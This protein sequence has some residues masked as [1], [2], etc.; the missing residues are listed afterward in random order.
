VLEPALFL[1]TAALCLLSGTRT[2]H[3]ALAPELVD[4]AAITVWA[5]AVVALLV[6]LQVE[7]SRLPVDD[8][9]THL[10]LTMI[11]EVMVLDH[12]GPDLAAI[13]TGAAVKLLV[14]ASFVATLLNPWGGQPT[15]LAA[16]TNV[17]LMIGVAVVVGT[18]ESLIARLKLRTVP[19]YVVVALVSSGI[20][21]LAAAFRA[22]GA[23]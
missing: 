11:H 19:E 9:T 16:A 14:G 2:L 3:E 12:S 22:G 8:P 23:L 10:E 1:V 17:G 4:G 6:V 18:V 20:A 13:Q 21:L 7:A 5:M 15:L